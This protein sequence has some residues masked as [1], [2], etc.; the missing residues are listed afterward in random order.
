MGTPPDDFD[1]V[2]MAR[3]ASIAGTHARLDL[4]EVGD[5]LFI[6]TV[7][8]NDAGGKY[9]IEHIRERGANGPERYY[10]FGLKFI[11]G[12]ADGNIQKPNTAQIQVIKPVEEAQAELGIRT[13]ISRG[14]NYFDLEDG[15]ASFNTG[16]YSVAPIDKEFY[17]NGRVLYINGFKSTLKDV[18]HQEDPDNP[19]GLQTQFK[20]EEYDSQGDGYS[21]LLPAGHH[22]T[23]SAEL[24]YIT[25]EYVDEELEKLRDEIYDESTTTVAYGNRKFIA[26]N[27]DK[28]SK[29]YAYNRTASGS[30]GT[31]PLA[32]SIDSLEVHK[33][34]WTGSSGP[35]MQ[36]GDFVPGDFLILRNDTQSARW[37]ITRIQ[38]R[39]DNYALD[40]EYI[41]GDENFNLVNDLTYN[42]D[43]E[44]HPPEFVKISGDEMTGTLTVPEIKTTKINSGTTDN[45]NF[46][47]NNSSKFY[48]TSQGAEVHGWLKL[49]FEGTEDYHAVT[50]AYVDANAGS[51]PFVNVFGKA[52]RVTSSM[53]ATTGDIMFTG[54]NGQQPNRWTDIERVK[55]WFDD[56][57]NY[58]PYVVSE[59]SPDAAIRIMLADT[60][61]TVLLV[62]ISGT[63]STGTTSMEWRLLGKNYIEMMTTIASG[64][65]VAYE[66]VNVFREA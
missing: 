24:P 16:T 25:T 46:Q 51:K 43:V 8:D 47:Y 20:I 26:K 34:P 50:K 11:A 49:N 18:N 39:A 61:Q 45:I 10:E 62:Q 65:E 58:A 30:S 17:Y 23:F 2:K 22:C 56:L 38:Y 35:V 57:D 59:L 52:R 7:S 40:L 4:A 29:G 31:T 42:L 19:I 66:L 5:I 53:G 13:Y 32:S 48:V 21:Q 54:A 14:K 55:I 15:K 3:I 36:D 28:P 60:G 6:Q 41:D 33:E 12:F 44:V 63:A 27:Y 37:E 1:Q 64:V 9:E